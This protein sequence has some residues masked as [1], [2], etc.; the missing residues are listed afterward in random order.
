[1]ARIAVLGVGDGGQG[2][3]GVPEP[4]RELASPGVEP[5]LVELKGSAFPGTPEGRAIAERAYVA[6]GIEAARAGCDAILV[7]TVGDYGLAALR[8]QVPVPVVGCGEAAVRAAQARGGVQGG[9]FAIVTLWPPRMGFIYRHVLADA[10]AQDDC[11]AIRFLSRDEDLETLHQGGDPISEFMTCGF[12]PMQEVRRVCEATLAET[13]ADALITGCTCMAGMLPILEG[14][15]LP[16][17]EPMRA[18]WRAAEAL[19]R[20]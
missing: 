16:V 3:E 6:A 18:G 20:R 14:W 17:V 1:M 15:G 4:I 12:A 19:A 5:V 7:N 2:G 8:A 10:G 13:G 9:G 11:R